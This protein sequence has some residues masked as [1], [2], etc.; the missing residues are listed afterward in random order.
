[1]AY[2]YDDRH[3]NATMESLILPK[4]QQHQAR[5]RNKTMVY[6]N[7]FHTKQHRRISRLYP[8]LF[9]FITVLAVPI[10]SWSLVLPSSNISRRNP[11]LCRKSY[12]VTKRQSMQQDDSNDSDEADTSSS[13][14]DEKNVSNEAK[15]NQDDNDTKD[16]SITDAS[17]VDRST[18]SSV[19][20][21]DSNVVSNDIATSTNNDN[22]TDRFKY[23]VRSP[24]KFLIR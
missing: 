4:F 18:M 24:K 21:L 20:S 1:M 7:C 6:C 19:E 5:E 8:V 3:H 15:Y 11:S 2:Y 10:H 16:S 14:T 17:D 23:K 9:L 22:M 13:A 12:R